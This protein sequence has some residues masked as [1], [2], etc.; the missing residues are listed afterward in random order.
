MVVETA[1]F[2]LESLA[3]ETEQHFAAVVAEGGRFVGMNDQ[4]MWSNGWNFVVVI[5]VRHC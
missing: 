5:G 1:A 3:H 4:G 2:A